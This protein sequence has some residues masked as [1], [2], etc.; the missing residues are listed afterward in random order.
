MTHSKCRFQ[1]REARSRCEEHLQQGAPNRPLVP[2]RRN[3]HRQSVQQS[4]SVY[5][6]SPLAMRCCRVHANTWSMNRARR[7]ISIIKPSRRLRTTQPEGFLFRR[8]TMFLNSQRNA[9]GKTARDLSVNESVREPT[10]DPPWR[11]GQVVCLRRCDLRTRIRR[12]IDDPRNH[13]K[14][15]RF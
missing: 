11:K 10:S 8:K 13:G 15:P 9:R 3:S 2:N 12:A 14:R 5:L 7:L 6:A 1:S 4:R